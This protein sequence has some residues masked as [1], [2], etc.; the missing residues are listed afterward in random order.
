MAKYTQEVDIIEFTGSNVRDIKKLLKIKDANIDEST[1]SLTLPGQVG[2]EKPVWAVK[3]GY[4]VMVDA[5]GTITV[6]KPEGFAKRDF[7]A[8]SNQ[9]TPKEKTSAKVDAK[10]S[11]K[12]ED[13]AQFDAK[14]NPE[15]DSH[16]PAPDTEK[17]PDMK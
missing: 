16:G 11:A 15:L 10:A 9:E 14:E 2:D 3:K 4:F 17:G 6:M 8:V 7:K 1:D 5:A 13:V 12:T